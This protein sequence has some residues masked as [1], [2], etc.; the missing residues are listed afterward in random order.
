[1]NTMNLSDGKEGLLMKKTK[2]FPVYLVDFL[3]KLKINIENEGEYLKKKKSK[4]S[5]E[6][7]FHIY[8]DDSRYLFIYLFVMKDSND[9]E[10]KR[11]WTLI[12]MTDVMCFI[13]L[14]LF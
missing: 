14:S 1:M 11:H 13:H 3:F 5:I 2:N 8:L 10:M 6:K 12:A 9:M 7:M 4:F